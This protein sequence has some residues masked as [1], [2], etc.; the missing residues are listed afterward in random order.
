MVSEDKKITYLAKRVI[1]ADGVAVTVMDVENEHIAHDEKGKL[2]CKF[3]R[4]E[5][6]SFSGY[7][8]S[9]EYEGFYSHGVR[10]GEGKNLSMLTETHWNTADWRARGLGTTTLSSWV[11]YS[12][13]CL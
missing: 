13:F 1:E 11:R 10:H 7:K 9:Y 12:E 8:T 6:G 4:E 5:D 3:K 2:L